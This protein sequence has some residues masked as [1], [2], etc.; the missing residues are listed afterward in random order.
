[1]RVD[2]APAENCGGLRPGCP[3][4]ARA[5]TADRYGGEG[6]RDDPARESVAPFSE[7]T[8]SP[9]CGGL[10]FERTDLI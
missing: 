10:F 4:T 6:V 8:V 5:R 3:V 9:Q 1:M 2:C 7:K